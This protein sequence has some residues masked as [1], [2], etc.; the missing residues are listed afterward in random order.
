VLHYL[1][2]LVLVLLVQHQ[3]VHLLVVL[4]LLQMLNFPYLFL[5]AIKVSPFLKSDN[6]GWGI[7]S[8]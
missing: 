1:L 7:A 4:L 2:L 8:V 3:Q 6:R 5:C